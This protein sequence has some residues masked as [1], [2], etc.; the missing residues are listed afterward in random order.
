ME[1]IKFIC[2]VLRIQKRKTVTFLYVAG[3][4]AS[5]QLCDSK[6][7]ANELNL[8]VMSII[9]G[10]CIPQKDSDGK[11]MYEICE[12]TQHIPSQYN[13]T[14]LIEYT[15]KALVYRLCKIKILDSIHHFLAG[16]GFLR[17][18][19]PFTMPFRGT[20]I[21]SPLSIKGRYVDRYCKITH[22]LAIK[23]LMAETLK[24]VFE[25]GYVARDAYNTQKNWFEYPVLEFVSPLH[26]ITFI[27]KFIK[28]MI[29][30]ATIIADKLSL[31]HVDLKQYEVIDLAE[32]EIAG[33]EEFT[34]LK[35]NI[36]NAIL[37]HSPVY[38]PL[39]KQLDGKR[40]ETIWIYKGIGIAHGYQDENN[41]ESVYAFC[42]EQLAELN[43]KSIVGE[44]P[45]DFIELL[46]IGMPSSVSLGMGIDRFLQT[47]FQIDNLKEYHKLFY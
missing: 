23:K 3:F 16:E 18:E 14:V 41:W 20:S 45:S 24:P 8:G 2:R 26:D 6:G 7:I 1:S 47:F 22:E 4:D 21:A 25:I 43:E 5:R 12:I 13:D 36:N 40:T 39:V 30:T 46:K 15:N 29:E 27:E 34:R 11:I 17:I 35:K 28:F 19:S 9:Q 38:S 32:N 42:N 10:E 33:K 44:L 37:I 31:E